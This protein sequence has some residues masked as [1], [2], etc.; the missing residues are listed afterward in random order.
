MTRATR[1]LVGMGLVGAGVLAGLPILVSAVAE[2]P[3]ARGNDLVVHEWGTFTSVSGADGVAL[4]WRP[5]AGP[6]DLPSFVYTSAGAPR[7]LRHGA[8]CPKCERYHC[9]CGPT[10]G[11]ASDG[12]GTQCKSCTVASVR[13][14]TPVLYFYAPRE[15]TVEVSVGF[16]RG[17]VTEW[18]PQARAV[19]RGIVWGGVRLLPGTDPALPREAAESH[20]YPAREVDA[21]PLRVCGGGRPAEHE[22]FLFYRGVGTFDLPLRAVLDGD[23]IAL[24]RAGT[25]PIP[26]AF[27]FERAGKACAWR[28]LG[29][30]D[31][32][33]SVP[34]CVFDGTHGDLPAALTGTLTAAGLHPKEAAAMVATWRDTWFEEGVRILYLVPRAVTDRELPLTIRPAPAEVVRVLV[35]RLEILTP[36]AEATIADAA[37]LLAHADTR[38][39]AGARATL[40]RYGR[41][42]EPVLRRVLAANP[43]PAVADAIRGL[44]D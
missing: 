23:G 38:V 16:P 41:F 13:M 11:C 7:G 44:L 18:Y 31:G 5:L 19:E 37:R 24:T 9:G 30:V 43:E 15:T 27:L 34:R 28:A 2:E 3:P 1:W 33:R 21:V 26:A 4:D 39:V 35:G 36:R 6:S 42:A 17:R 25:E 14:E 12:G 8:A 22:R 10:C 20:Y 32:P 29:P 40:A